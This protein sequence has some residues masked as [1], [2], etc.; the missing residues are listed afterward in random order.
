VDKLQ[1]IDCLLKYYPEAARLATDTLSRIHNQILATPVATFSLG[2]MELLLLVAEESQHQAYEL[3]ID[4]TQFSSIVN[5]I[6]LKA[7]ATD[8]VSN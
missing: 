5:V 3:L 1:Q 6:C 2:T 4:D 7:K 8:K